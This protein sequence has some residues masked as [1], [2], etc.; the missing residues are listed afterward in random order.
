MR[1]R[2]LCLLLIAAGALAVAG[3]GGSDKNTPATT[4]TVAA[5]SSVAFDRAFIDA[6]VPHHESAIEMARAAKARGL[7]QPDL[8]RIAET[9]IV[10]QQLEIDDMR[11]WRK[12]W[13]GSSAIDPDGAA[14]LGL[15]E[16]EM[17]MQHGSADF[18]SAADVD[19]AFAAMMIDHHRGAIRMAELAQEKGQHAEIGE[20][21][22]AIIS[23]Q[24]REIK[25]LEPHA[26]GAHHG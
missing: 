1:A 18:E 9:I 20:L 7:S 5:P 25:Q 12:Q 14:G 17:G 10:T 2:M 13:F 4:E 26:S 24:E 19:Q 15:S 23:T 22:G 6:M 21:A 3:C 11:R 16:E 8:Q